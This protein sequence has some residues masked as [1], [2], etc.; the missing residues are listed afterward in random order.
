LG[1]RLWYLCVRVIRY[2][3]HHHIVGPL[4][5]CG[6]FSGPFCVKSFAFLYRPI[7]YL[8]LGHNFL[9]CGCFP[10][11]FC[12]ICKVVTQ[13][14]LTTFSFGVVWPCVFGQLLT[15]GTQHFLTTFSLAVV[16]P[17]CICMV[18]AL[19]KSC[20]HKY[21]EFTH[22]VFLWWKFKCLVRWSAKKERRAWGSW[23]ITLGMW[24]R[25]TLH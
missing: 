7:Q 8:R 25:P 23:R 9:F 24:L 6:V 12:T 19:C 21:V 11:V 16:S 3:V 5:R 14:F 18:V 10:C 1:V 20:M 22:K 4:G 2:M 13:H 17:T 15:V